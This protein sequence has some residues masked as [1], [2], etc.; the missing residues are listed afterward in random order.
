MKVSY[1]TGSI[2][3]VAGQ[4][5]K[6]TVAGASS[7]SK[8]AL[9][10]LLRRAT[11]TSRQRPVPSFIKTGITGLATAILSLCGR[12]RYDRRV[13][14]L[15]AAPTQSRPPVVSP[16]DSERCDRAA[17]LEHQQMI[18]EPTYCAGDNVRMR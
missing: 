11:M 18:V 12:D 8:L 14:A 4:F 7:A 16:Y 13:H 3:L 15:A 5:T 17:A 1:V 10:F 9:D 2:L 6:E